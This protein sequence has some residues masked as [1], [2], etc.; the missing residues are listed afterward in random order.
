MS[1]TQKKQSSWNTDRIIGI[2]AMLVGLLTLIIFIYQ[3][4]IMREQSRLAVKPRLSFGVNTDGND[5]TTSISMTLTNKGLGP[6][7]IDS[8][9]ISEP[10][11]EAFLDFDA[12][13]ETVHPEVAKLGYFRQTANIKR[14]GV[15]AAN[16]TFTFFVFVVETP[17]V[18]TLLQKLNMSEDDP[19]PWT[20][21]VEYSS[22]YDERWFTTDKMEDHPVMIN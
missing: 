18:P 8:L 17:K 22:M 20:I 9:S 19:F 7:M 1:E 12:F 11:S 2:V 16:E 15:I 21:H 13:L 3:T 4:N 5:Q 10:G 6:A 14:G